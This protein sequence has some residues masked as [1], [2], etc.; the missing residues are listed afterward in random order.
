MVRQREITHAI[1]SL[2]PATK[3]KNVNSL[4]GLGIEVDNAAM[5]KVIKALTV[6]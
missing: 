1:E 2:A 3:T 4:V 6:C 5:A